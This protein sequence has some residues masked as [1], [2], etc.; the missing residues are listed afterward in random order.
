MQEKDANMMLKS[1][2]MKATPDL[3]R[4]LGYIRDDQQLEN[5]PVAEQYSISINRH[6]WLK[7]CMSEWRRHK[8]KFELS[9]KKDYAGKNQKCNLCNT[10][11]K[12]S[13]FHVY[14][15]KNKNELFIGSDCCGHVLNEDPAL[16]T[17][18]T[19]KRY[20]RDK[21][22]KR[23]FKELDNLMYHLPSDGSKFEVTK[24][25]LDFEHRLRSDIKKVYK[26]YLE[27]SILQSNLDVLNE[28]IERL[29][30]MIKN[31]DVKMENL[32]GLSRDLLYRLE[33]K[34]SKS[35][36]SRVRRIV[37][38]NKG[39][40]NTDSASI[41]KDTIFLKGYV[42][43]LNMRSSQFENKISIF[44]LG[45][46]GTIAVIFIF[47]NIYVELTYS[48]N[49]V[50]ETFGYPVR[51]ITDENINSLIQQQSVPFDEESKMNL[52]KYGIR[53]LGNEG[54]NRY[55]LEYNNFANYVKD[56]EKDTPEKDKT[57]IKKSNLNSII[58]N[59][60][61][62]EN[63]GSYNIASKKDLL[64]IGKRQ[65]I[66]DFLGKTNSKVEITNVKSSKTN[67]FA[68]IFNQYDAKYSK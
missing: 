47:N 45:I 30:R 26:N 42:D 37:Q 34:Q 17:T 39:L 46:N 8:Q 25:I 36:V 24:D 63:R 67:L 31:N 51:F 1:E 44:K 65:F 27:G 58:R 7:Q 48:S 28:K 33:I 32:D 4:I 50:I 29:G 11:L 21:E 52:S 10:T 49:D 19:G 14:N 23:D 60:L 61:I 3:N 54:W 56:R 59:I 2:F 53:K 64:N 16:R 15:I 13:V 41:I 9:I 68:Y 22:F 40:L 43:E 35:D 12:K 57:K 6:E 20:W 55:S 38:E 62:F 66:N 5:L 18:L